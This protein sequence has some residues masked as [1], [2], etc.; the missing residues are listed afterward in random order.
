[1]RY[2]W[3]RKFEDNV[4]SLFEQGKISAPVHLSGDNS[5]AIKRIFGNIH[6]KDYVFSNWR[7][8][9][10]YLLHTGN[11]KGLLD[12]ILGKETGICKGNARSMHII[13]RKHNFFSSAIVAGCV[14]M[15]VGVAWALKEKQSRRMVHIFLGDGAFDSGFT[16]EAVRYAQGFNLPV[17]FYYEDNNRSVCTTKKQR[18]GI[19]KI[20]KSKVHHYY[21]KARWPH[22]GTGKWVSL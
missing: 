21:Y 19:T 2:C 8:H 9:Y 22:C 18:W 20:T 14:S 16:Y 17:I 11:D 15:A 3:L 6:K 1:M 10:H 4:A 5:I 13:D 12:E 7:S